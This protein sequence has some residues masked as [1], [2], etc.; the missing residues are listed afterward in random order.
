M[1]NESKNKK[2]FNAVLNLPGFNSTAAISFGLDDASTYI[3]DFKIKQYYNHPSLHISGCNSTITI[4]LDYT[5]E[6]D[7]KNSL[8]KL[9]QL[10]RSIARAKQLLE[11]AQLFNKQ[12]IE[13]KREFYTQVELIEEDIE[14]DKKDEI[15][16]NIAKEV[17]EKYGLI[18]V[19]EDDF[20]Y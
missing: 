3:G 10:E 13:A 8:F 4:D 15:C 17:I 2:A 19:E 12:I 1:I 5:E 16:K 9:N 20:D 7:Y 11:E 6:E 18:K 14:E